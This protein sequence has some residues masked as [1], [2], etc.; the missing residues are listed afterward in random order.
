M[1]LAHAIYGGQSSLNQHRNYRGNKSKHVDAKTN[2][3]SKRSA[4]ARGGGMQP[5][6]IQNNIVA[7]STSGAV[8]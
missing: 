7:S 8:N 6:T 2:L 3:Q 5:P 1:P 4:A